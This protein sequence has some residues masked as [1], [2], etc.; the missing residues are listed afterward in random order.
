M[1]FS[2]TFG[3]PWWGNAIVAGLTRIIIVAVTVVTRTSPALRCKPSSDCR[4][5][6]LAKYGRSL[7]RAYATELDKLRRFAPHDARALPTLKRW[8]YRDEKVLRETERMKLAATCCSSA[9]FMPC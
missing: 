9:L 8:L 2:G 6:V 4:Y 5:D 7:K 3:L 1:I